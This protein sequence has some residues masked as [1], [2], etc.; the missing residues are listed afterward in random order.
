MGV[1]GTLLARGEENPIPFLRTPDERFAELPDY[2]FEPHYVTLS[3]GL[4]MHYVDEGKGE[5]ILCLHG[6]PTWSYLYRK[7]IPPLSK[8]YR[9]IAPDLLG[10][11]KSDKPTRD[12]DFTF[13]FQYRSLVEF[14]EKLDLRQVTLVCQDWGGILGL[15]VAM[16]LQERFARLVIMNTGLPGGKLPLDIKDPGFTPRR[17]AAALA[18]LQWKAI[19]A[20]TRD[21]DIG[22][23]IQLG[24]VAK[25]SPEVLAA[26]NAP[27]PDVHYKVGP[28]RFPAIVPISPN[29]PAIPYTVRASQKL[30]QWHKPAL[31]MFSDQDPIFSGTEDF[32]RNLIPSAKDEPE[33]VI[34]TASHFLQEEKGEE[35]AQEILAFV[36]RRPIEPEESSERK[37][38]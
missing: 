8:E 7:I 28:V 4:R 14:I 20:K 29:D 34:R 24:S 15:P 5:I 12:E 30:A 17:A 11:G 35:I 1:L 16:D 31:V 19:A 10:F 27:Y 37:T 23:I 38:P 13:E 2:P 25:L 33:I 9:V 3:Q 32:F 6:E 36:K 21:L 26:Y 18:F 22:A